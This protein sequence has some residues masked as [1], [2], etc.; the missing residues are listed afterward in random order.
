MT[1]KQDHSQT[2]A[3][4][5]LDLLSRFA[6]LAVEQLPP[7][8]AYLKRHDDYWRAWWTALDGAREALWEIIRRCGFADSTWDQIE[9]EL[10]AAEQCL[11]TESEV[12]HL[13][14]SLAEAR[15]H[16]RDM[17]VFVDARGR[18]PQSHFGPDAGAPKSRPSRLPLPTP[19]VPPVVFDVPDAAP[20]LDTP[21]E[22]RRRHLNAGLGYLLHAVEM[23]D[24]A[25]AVTRACCDW[26]SAHGV[27]LHEDI[28]GL[29]LNVRL[30][31]RRALTVR[32]R[33]IADR[34]ELVA[35]TAVIEAGW[36]WLGRI[37][38]HGYGV[39]LY[40]DA[41][42]L[43]ASGRAP[44]PR[45]AALLPASLSQRWWDALAEAQG[46]ATVNGPRAVAARTAALRAKD[47][48]GGR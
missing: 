14:V 30:M 4:T 41:G 34:Q 35:K 7:S 42:Q 3:V 2:L 33:E 17:R 24:V 11:P 32:L 19:V 45:D 1:T 44:M 18:V 21:D 6:R 13:A 43:V 20:S 12:P 23:F 27:E 36:R 48:A 29:A 47:A 28:R 5:T 38:R 15:R 25:A 16:L 8:P 39:A 46:Y 10:T 37:G 22:R 31:Y 26:H 9:Q 40:N